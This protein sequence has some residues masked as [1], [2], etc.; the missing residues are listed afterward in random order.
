MQATTTS[1]GSVDPIPS[2]A[3]PNAS[4]LGVATTVLYVLALLAVA[5]IVIAGL[6]WLRGAALTPM[7]P[8][9]AQS[10][11]RMVSAWDEAGRRMEAPPPEE[12][13]GYEPPPEG[14]EQ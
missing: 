6:K 10:R 9:N 13:P 3:A 5:V 8:A 11:R 7:R 14:K 12:T 2:S 4:K 1:S